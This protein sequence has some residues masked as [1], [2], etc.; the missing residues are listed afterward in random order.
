[1]IK[2]PCQLRRIVNQEIY[3]SSGHYWRPDDPDKDPIPSWLLEIK[4][5]DKYSRDDFFSSR[6]VFYPG[7]YTDGHAVKVFGSTHAA[8]SFVYVDYWVTQEDLETELVKHA[9]LGV[10][11]LFSIQVSANDL[12][13]YGWI[14]CK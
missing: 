8:H 3:G 10:E 11:N 5:G 7:S 6:I 4:E 14:C 2:P 12:A 9:F 13:P 1:M